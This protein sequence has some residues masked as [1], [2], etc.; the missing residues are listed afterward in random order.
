MDVEVRYRGRDLSESDIRFIEQLIA[1]HPE[2]SRRQLSKR[3]CEAWDWR[4]QNGSLRDITARGLMLHLHRQ[5]YI[6]LPPKRCSP[7]NN[8]ARHRRPTPFS[9]PPYEPLSGG[10]AEIRPLEVRQVRRTDNEELFDRLIE[11]YHYLGYVRP[12]G[13]HLKM[14]FYSGDVPVACMA[15]GSPPRHLGARDRFIGWSAKVRRDN[16][17]LIAYQ[18]RFVV[19]P[20][21]RIN[22]LASHVL[23]LMARRISSEWQNV[24]DHPIYF[25]ETFVDPTRYRGTCYRAANWILLG[26]TTG[27]GKDDQTNKQN[28]SIKQVWGYPLVRNFRA[29]LGVAS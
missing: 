15:F 12:V 20:W 2:A 19:L 29:R 14:M 13:E 23:G 7:P 5:G 24:Y 9:Q 6:E 22:C 16:R 3:L 25:L 1:N 27:R 8:I 10:L 28:R 21:A 4:R 26:E 18:P 11:S 17:H